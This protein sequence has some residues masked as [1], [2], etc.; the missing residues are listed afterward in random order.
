MSK[1]NELVFVALGGLGEIGMNLGLYGLGPAGRRT[2]LMVDCGVTFA[3][4]EHLPGVDLILPD[5]TFIEAE[6]A[7]LAGIVLT[8]AH[9]DH[10]GALPDLWE[11]LGKPPVYATPFT[12]GLLEAK[13]ADERG[14]PDI[15]VETV[16]LEG[17]FDV[18]PFDIELVSVT[19]SIPEPNSLI[20]RTAAG[21]VLHTGDWKVDPDPVIGAPFD[22]APF[23]AL[24]E[25]GCLAVV[26]DSTNAIRDGRSPGEGDVSQVLAELVAAAPARVA[27]TCFASNVARIRSVAEAAAAAKRQV[28]IVGRA[29]KRT[30]TVARELGY[31]DGLPAFLG[32][33]NYA[34][35][36]RA[37]IVL[38]CTGSQGEPRAALTRVAA[39]NHPTVTLGAG[40]RVIYSARTIPGNERE[41]GAV[42]NSLIRGGVDVITD[43]THLVHVSG[44]PRRDELRNLYDWVRPQ[45]AVPV[46]GEALHLSE[47]AA[48]AREAGVKHVVTAYNGDVVLIGPG[49]ARIVDE[50]PSGRLY[51]DG[52]VMVDADSEGVRER[53]RLSFA[54]CV[55]V[56]VVVDG[57]GDVVSD[58]VMTLIGLPEADVEGRSFE[59]IVADAIDEVIDTLP[60]GRR[61][62]PDAFGEALRRAVRGGVSAAWGK[63]TLC[64]IH[65]LTV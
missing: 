9:E 46:H 38:L 7:S 41:V 28:V 11:R 14:A 40:D 24:G 60:R 47:H 59:D 19:H 12:A 56:S 22:S 26:G 23:A 45:V 5:I 31:L 2:W 35:L 6:R 33:E 51:K 53:R 57:R 1:T 13:L 58:P 37:R 55:T 27:V 36:D 3:A 32:E 29:M 17:R 16:P 54:G 15:S 50:A 44:H 42:I 48:L 8:H 18:G 64:E 4:E 65:V 39:G 30:I 21:T 25:E 63:K 10:F 20:I 34:R 52:L 49:K 43:R 62:D 61:R